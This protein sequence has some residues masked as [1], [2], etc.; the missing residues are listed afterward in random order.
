[1]MNVT[2]ESSLHDTEMLNRAIYHKIANEVGI[3]KSI[4]Q[5]ILYVSRGQD[6]L[7]EQVIARIEQISDEL[8]QR[9]AAQQARVATIPDDDYERL[10]DTISQTA[11]DIS[12]F[13]NNQLATLESQIRRIM[14]QLPADDPHYAQFEK[15]LDQLELTQ[16][17]LNDLKAIN[18][19]ITI[20]NMRFKVKSLFEKWQT[21]PQIGNATI[22]L[23][24]YN[25]DA[26]ISSDA[27]KIKSALNELVDNTLKHNADKADLEIRI[28]ARDVINP[29]RVRGR[30][31]PGK[32]KYLFIEFSDNGQ[33]VPPD[34]KEW[35][36][37]PLKTS[38]KEGRGSG[39]GLFIIR[40]TLRKMNAYIIE[41]GTDG[42]RFELYIPYTEGAAQ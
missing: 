18:E 31:I 38:A 14:W 29:P 33:G 16:N 4:A 36:F 2:T 3:L 24:I 20:R 11:H 26:E 41:T 32:Q 13:V 30:T 42:A 22:A 17:A 23:E 8:V 12:D 27:E 25:G 35:I 6:G 21:N 10:I 40:K 7:L 39:L 28:T 19:G 9:R 1:M 37:L 15:L 5:R 34:K